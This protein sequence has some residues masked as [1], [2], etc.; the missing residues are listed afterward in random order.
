MVPN[1]KNN[2]NLYLKKT[3]Y[4][5]HYR[6]QWNK[7]SEEIQTHARTPHLAA[8]AKRFERVEAEPARVSC[9]SE[10]VHELCVE[11][12]L[13]GRQTHQNHMLLLRRQLVLQDIVASSGL[14]TNYNQYSQKPHWAFLLWTMTVTLTSVQSPPAGCAGR[15]S[16]TS[17][18]GCPEVCCP[19]TGRS[20]WDARTCCWTP[21]AYL[22]CA[23]GVKAAVLT[24]TANARLLKRGTGCSVPRKSGRT[25]STMHQYSIRL[26][27][28]G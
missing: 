27:W 6:H 22:K 24:L 8:D 2:A 23:Q 25:K 12:P 21:A 4:K 9:L 26:F 28:S 10:A 20:E 18:A 17:S 14:K 3:I 5:C 19:H 16:C 7:V 1:L 11:G 15:G 13:Q